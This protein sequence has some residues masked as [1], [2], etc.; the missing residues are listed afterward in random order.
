M[1]EFQ[2]HLKL[3]NYLPSHQYVLSISLDYLYRQDVFLQFPL[4]K[5]Q[6]RFLIPLQHDVHFH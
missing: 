4:L 2:L 3:L 1:G 6:T 5:L